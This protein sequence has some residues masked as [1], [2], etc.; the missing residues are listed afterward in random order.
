LEKI[1]F[2]GT[3][4][5]MRA[6][7]YQAEAERYAPKDA[8]SQAEY[9]AAKIQEHDLQQR[10]DEER[11]KLADAQAR[12]AK[13]GGGDPGFST[14][15]IQ[16]SIDDKKTLSESTAIIKR[17]TEEMARSTPA[18][19]VAALKAK[20]DEQ[21]RAATA[22]ARAADAAAAAK[23]AEG[24]PAASTTAA[25][26]T[27]ENPAVPATLTAE[28]VSRLERL[29]TQENALREAAMA[30]NRQL[31]D[32]KSGLSDEQKAGLTRQLTMIGEQVNNQHRMI[33]ELI[34]TNENL[35]N[36]YREF[37]KGKSN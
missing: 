4:A 18:A 17:L 1:G 5:S 21:D 34:K 2:T 3:A 26:A 16:M 35:T 15:G 36:L 6:S 29:E 11:Q 37:R 27:P 20:R 33:D 14:S 30:A 10:I 23:P 31:I 9:V 12:A 7:A 32:P 24:S 8:Q 25:V 13:K 28:Q 19:T 22:A